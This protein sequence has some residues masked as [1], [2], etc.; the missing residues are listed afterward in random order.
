MHREEV[1]ITSTDYFNV[2][3]GSRLSEITE[4]DA[5]I[6]IFWAGNLSYYMNRPA[7]DFLGKS[8]RF[9]A[10]NPPVREVV[11]SKYNFSD[12]VPGHNKW[13]FKYSIGE[14]K[15]DVITRNWPDPE[16]DNQIELNNYKTYCINIT[17]NKFGDEFPIYVK[18]NSENIKY[19][20]LIN[21]SNEN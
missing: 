1:Q 12:F 20:K 3:I 14:L 2:L 7:V 15:P 11:S 17:P 16:F 5:R 6:G 18:I 13:N 19:D 21:C 10:K 9:I 4:P 8:D